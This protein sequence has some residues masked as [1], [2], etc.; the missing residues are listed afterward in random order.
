M[1]RF[2]IEVPDGHIA[3]TLATSLREKS[4]YFESVAKDHEAKVKQQDYA[5]KRLMLDSKFFKDL[6]KTIARNTRMP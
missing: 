3:F 6:A 4:A 1:P 5:Y 2:Q